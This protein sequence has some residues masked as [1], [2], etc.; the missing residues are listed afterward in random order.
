[1]STMNSVMIG[2]YFLQSAANLDHSKT[3]ERESAGLGS[4]ILPG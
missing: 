2:D 1:M 4:C 3:K